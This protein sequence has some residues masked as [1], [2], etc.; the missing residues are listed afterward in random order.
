MADTPQKAKGGKKNRKVG[1]S[2][3][4]CQSYRAEHRRER[5][6]AVRLIGHTARQPND[7][8]GAAALKRCF[9]VVSEANVRKFIER[10][11]AGV[12]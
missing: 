3:T 2:K 10:R 9:A 8:C 4:Y 11:I 7:E 5:N 12:V 6:K 1:R